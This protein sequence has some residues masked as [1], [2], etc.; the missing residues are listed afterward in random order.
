M[1]Y[2]NKRIFSFLV[3]LLP[4]M[5]VSAQTQKTD[6]LQNQFLQYHSQALQEKIFVHIDK[7]FYLAGEN[8]WFKIYDVDGCANKP[9]NISKI[10]YVEIINKEQKSLLQT[11]V[12]LKE[13]S[14]SGSLTIP[15]SIASGNYEFRCYTNWMKNFD[16]DFYF[17]QQLTIINTLNPSAINAKS[18]DI[19]S[20]QFF[21]EGGN[22][23]QGL[24]STIGFKAT[25][26]NGEGI[27]CAG[28][29]INQKNDTVA[30]F[31]SFRFGIGHFI[32]TPAKDE[33]YYAVLKINDSVV[34]RQLPTAYEKG[35]VMNLQ[36]T[37]NKEI[38]ITVRASNILPSD[39]S[40][41]LFVHSHHIIKYAQ[42]SYITNGEA[43]FILDKKSLGDG[44]SHFTVFNSYRQP[45][46]ERLYFIQPEKKFK[47]N[48]TSTQQE[49]GPRK[50]VNIEFTATDQ[51]STP[52]KANMSLSVFLIDSFQSVP[53]Q[54]ITNYLL[55]SSDLKGRIE[56][57]QYYF[58]NFG[59][60][61]NE[62]T[63]NLMLTQG[64]SRFK[65]DDVLQNKKPVFEFLP[66]IEGPVIS[67]KVTDKKKGTVARQVLGY[68]T[69]PGLDFEF[70]S[71]ATKLNG[72]IRF[73]I[74]KIYGR[75]EMI[76]QT[77]SQTSDSNFR[78][79]I[80][81]AFS[82]KISSLILPN[83]SLSK[84]WEPQLLERSI[85]MQVENSYLVKK[86]NEHV[87]S[88]DADTTLFYGKPEDQY[89]LDDYTR[90]VTME[91]V[92]R[93]YIMDV[94]VKKQSE[95]FHF[96]VRNDIFNIFFETDPLILID[97]LPVFDAD[98]IMA[99]DPLKIKKIDIVT[100]KYYKGPLINDGVVSYKTYD[101]DLAGYQLDPNALVME[102]E[103]LQ[104]QKEFYSPVY[105]TDE[106]IKSPIPDFRNLLMWAPEIKTDTLGK[107]QLSF[108]T[109]GVKG[110]FAVLIQGLTDE[111][112]MG[113]T[114]FTF[115]V[116]SDKQ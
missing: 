36:E 110:K 17:E 49:Y 24:S 39:P 12:E 93:E 98:K 88:A 106:Q 7:T 105:E 29:I 40:V 101:G 72:D 87:F 43:D 107:N 67:G 31:Q 20:I 56:S 5:H 51:L 16:P 11:K 19:F 76:V 63:D 68:L 78:I 44:I 38:K 60:E 52:V 79:D 8:I 15:S 54:N 65:W 103:G 27:D 86:K 99:V 96:R 46:C 57:P 13:G 74:R 111:G 58:E 21:P 95:K 61:V 30:K 48:A 115:D 100:Y 77:N 89:Y 62:A 50:K 73:N 66:E 32:L 25:N 114:I 109:S 69:I 14:G 80:A 34:V 70:S 26:Q 9:L 97:G 104:R 92:M 23:V 2:I 75:N 47:I 94:R 82:D 83:L 59:P 1:M 112:L 37:N 84:K 55:L 116:A 53:E 113:S 22:L 4:Y 41:Y 28:T 6:S 102:Y 85:N 71:A 35:F 90:F 42:L 3:L 64:W 91:E 10:A 18:A 45:V 33:K 108:Y 81:N